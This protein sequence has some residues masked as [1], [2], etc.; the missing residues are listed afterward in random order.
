MIVFLNDPRFEGECWNEMA[1][2]G[3]VGM[4]WLEW[5][6]LLYFGLNY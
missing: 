3:W 1:G 6:G 5:I 2:M 4:E